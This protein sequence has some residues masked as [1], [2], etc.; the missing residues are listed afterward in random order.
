MPKRIFI[1][2]L[3]AIVIITSLII[4]IMWF[5]YQ[6]NQLVSLKSDLETVRR[7]I[8]FD[9]QSNNLN[10]TDNNPRSNKNSNSSIQ[11]NSPLKTLK[12]VNIGDWGDINVD[13]L[14][15]K[16]IEVYYKET[17]FTDIITNGD[18]N[19]SDTD[20]LETLVENFF[21]PLMDKGVKL[22]FSLGN[23]DVENIDKL[24]QQVNNPLYGEWDCE[25]C[26]VTRK[27]SSNRRYYSFFKYP[28]RFIILDSNLM[29]DQ[30]KDQDGWLT[31]E[32]KESI[33]K[34]ENWQILVFHHP[35][36]SSAQRH[37]NTENFI[38][39]YRDLFTEF[40]VDVVLSGHDHTYERIKTSYECG[41]NVQ[42]IV[43]GAIMLRYDDIRKPNSCTET[44]WDESPT[45]IYVEAT[46]QMIYGKVITQYGSVVDSWKI[47]NK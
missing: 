47:L 36:F 27:E 43:N 20:N 28:V 42:Y 46:A 4:L 24:L 1:K 21:R 8:N 44:H 37:G 9:I 5:I 16:R 17:L 41:K 10:N 39:R 25:Q 14:I 2:Q 22:H 33:L 40:G 13:K 26:L 11:Q 3:I 30:D 31:A 35:L 29:L 32:L 19:Y 45:F 15:F 18:N 23:H 7:D 6:L 38:S 34:G 12:F